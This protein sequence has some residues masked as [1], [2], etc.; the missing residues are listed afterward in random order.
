MVVEYGIM[1]NRWS[2]E[3]DDKL[4]AYACIVIHLNT[5]AN[6]VAL[7]SPKEIVKNDSWILSENQ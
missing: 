2:V 4:T 7:F 1:S 3:A 6:K 5:S